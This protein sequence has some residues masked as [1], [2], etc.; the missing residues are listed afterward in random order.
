M[1]TKQEKLLMWFLVLW[2]ALLVIS[3]AFKIKTSMYVLPFFMVGFIMWLIVLTFSSAKSAKT[4]DEN[5]KQT[6]KKE[7]K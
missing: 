4:E 5:Q 6:N 1:E 2:I 7:K 3:I